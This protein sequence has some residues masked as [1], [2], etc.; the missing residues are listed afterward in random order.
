MVMRLS[1]CLVP[2]TISLD[3]CVYELFI[4]FVGFFFVHVF[5]SLTSEC[6]F[7]HIRFHDDILDHI[8][9]VCKS[10]DQSRIH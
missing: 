8:V 5:V 2:A 7:H 4:T 9:L 6:A 1:D 10:K 3:A